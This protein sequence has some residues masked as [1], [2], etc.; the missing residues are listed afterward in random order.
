[1]KFKRKI[2]PTNCTL[3]EACVLVTPNALAAGRLAAFITQWNMVADELGRA[4][5]QKE[6][7]EYWGVGRATVDRR[8]AEFRRAFNKCDTPSDLPRAQKRAELGR[9]FQE[10]TGL[11]VVG[12]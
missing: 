1:M 4:P 2:D 5:T 7:R 6:Y 8:L 9:D 10:L 3:S 11:R 12:G